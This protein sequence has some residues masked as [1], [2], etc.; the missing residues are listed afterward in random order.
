MGH[1]SAQCTASV[2]DPFPFSIF[3]CLPSTNS[4]LFYDSKYWSKQVIR[5][6]LGD[7]FLPA[8]ETRVRDWNPSVPTPHRRCIHYISKV[9]LVDSHLLQRFDLETRRPRTFLSSSCLRSW[10]ATSSGSELDTKPRSYSGSR[11]QLGCGCHLGV[12]KAGGA[13]VPLSA[14]KA[15]ERTLSILE[16]TKS[17][18][19]STQESYLDSMQSL[20]IRLSRS[21]I[22]CLKAFPDRSRATTVGPR[23]FVTQTTLFS[24]QA[25]LGSLRRRYR[26]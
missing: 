9:R 10:P 16:Q 13:F 20:Y 21:T 17:Q 11:N 22:D 2:S 12:L 23:Q 24:I 4:H 1:E 5:S 14:G 6:M 8:D 25:V 18:L 26:A 15:D 3:V 7:R 19:V